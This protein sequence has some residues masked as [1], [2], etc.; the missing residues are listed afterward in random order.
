MYSE[1]RLNELGYNEH[2]VITNK[3][4]SKIGHIG[5]QINPVIKNPGYNEQKLSGPELFV[6]T[7]FDC[8]IK[9]QQK[10]NWQFI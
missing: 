1:T 8:S 10:P 3:F 9:F 2:S 5:T 4:L 7:E 6:I